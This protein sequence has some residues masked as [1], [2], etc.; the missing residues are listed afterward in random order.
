MVE[1]DRHVHSQ[2]SPAEL[3]KTESRQAE[4]ASQ[5]MVYEGVSQHWA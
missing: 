4:L 2:T 5:E 1:R 3:T